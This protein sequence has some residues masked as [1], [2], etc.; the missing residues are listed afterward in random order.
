[1][2]ELF[3]GFDSAWVNKN[4]G[5]IA[6]YML[7]GQGDC[8]FD[9]PALATFEDAADFIN[10]EAARADYVLIAIDQP[11]IVPNSDGCRPVDRVAGSM[12]SRL[13]GGVQ[14]A[15]RAGLA[16]NM[17][18]DN[19]PIWHFLSAVAARQAP[20]QA[21]K[22]VTGRFLIEVFPALA[23]PAMIPEIWRRDRAAKYNPANVK[24]DASDWKLVARGLAAYARLHDLCEL[25]HWADAQA[26]LA[27]PRKV[28]QDRLD[29][30]I[31]L[32]IAMVWRR[33]PLHDSVQLGDAAT[34]YIVTPVTTAT[35]AVLTGAAARK[36][37]AI[38]AD[39]CDSA[40]GAG[41][42]SNQ[43]GPSSSPPV[44]YSPSQSIPRRARQARE[45]AR[46]ARVAPDE[47]REL[48]V[49]CA[50]SGSTITYGG[51]AAEFKFPWSQGFGA[52]LTR[53]LNILAVENRR[54]N[55]PVLMCLVVNKET[56]LP[57]QGYY[58]AIGSAK[59]DPHS[60]RDIFLDEVRRCT[61][62]PW[63]EHER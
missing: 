50:R 9:A 25:A 37:V 30:A 10:R 47:L 53:A 7:D 27:R 24:F 23:L 21:R 59:D 6:A 61:A 8:R 45:T 40:P 51:V 43:P 55:E 16:Q 41:E 36:G 62:W 60:Q 33:F 20:M 42:Q 29:A 46:P 49:R 48:L 39:W 11:T 38:D 28:D 2:K 35:R 26:Q 58:S 1:M 31:C 12:I 57:G 14:P 56:G 18:G 32:A 54:C 13:G 3:I 63:K 17:F 34:G 4:P 15:R 19:A 52:S 44:E 5:A 22:A